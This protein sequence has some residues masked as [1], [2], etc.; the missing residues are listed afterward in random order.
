MTYIRYVGTSR[1]DVDSKVVTEFFW[2]WLRFWTMLSPSSRGI[3]L[4]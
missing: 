2:F 1:Y 3:R 4:F